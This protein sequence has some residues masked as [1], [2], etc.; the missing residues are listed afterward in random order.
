MRPY[1]GFFFFGDGAARDA[2]G[3]LWIKGRVRDAVMSIR[4]LDLQ[5]H[6]SLDDI[7]NSSFNPEVAVRISCRSVTEEEEALVGFTA[8]LV[9][10]CQLPRSSLP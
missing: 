10:D 2:D 6:D 8:S 3:Y 5:M 1:K 7:V 9:T 4:G